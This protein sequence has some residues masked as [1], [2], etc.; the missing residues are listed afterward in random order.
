MRA[1][2][3]LAFGFTPDW[4]RKRRVCADILKFVV[5]FFL[6]LLSP[7]QTDSQVVASSHKFKLR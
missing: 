1:P 3:S 7:G 5:R 2:G 6:P 4:L